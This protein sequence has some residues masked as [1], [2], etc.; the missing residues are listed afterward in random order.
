LTS[1]RWSLGAHRDFRNIIEWLSDHNPEAASRIADRIQASVGMLKTHPRLGRLG[2]VDG[3][4]ELIISGSPY[5][6][7]YE[8]APAEQQVLIV[9]ILHSAR[10]WPTRT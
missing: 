3:T 7:I 6:V 4:R 8:I 9:R 1:L 2:R 10:R 5:L